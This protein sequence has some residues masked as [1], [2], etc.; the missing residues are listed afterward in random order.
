MPLD[1]L[2]V[3]KSLRRSLRRYVVRTDTEFASV[4]L[5]CADPRRPHGWITRSFVDAYTNLHHLGWSHSVE[6]WRDGVLVGGLYGVAV[7]GLFAGESMFHDATDASK[8]ALVHLVALLRRHG[9]RLLDVQWMTPHLA[10]L[11]AV[12]MSRAAYLESLGDA[13]TV[14]GGWEP[15]GELPPTT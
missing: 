5:R 12:A 15:P 3:S 10:S 14:P 13:V 8:V 1:G 4:M 7:G 11:G 6:T 2:R 9:Y